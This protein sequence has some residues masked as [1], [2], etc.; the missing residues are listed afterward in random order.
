MAENDNQSQTEKDSKPEGVGKSKAMG[1]S[2]SPITGLRVADPD[3]FR[4][5]AQGVSPLLQS[6]DFEAARLTLQRANENILAMGR[7]LGLLD[8]GLRVD[9]YPTTLSLAPPAEMTQLS[10]R[11]AKIE[12]GLN[13][14]KAGQAKNEKVDEPLL[15]DLIETTA[16]AKGQTDSMLMARLH[17]PPQ[18]LT[19]Q[20][21]VPVTLLERLEEYRSDENLLLLFAGTF[22]GAILGVLGS[23]FV[24]EDQPFSKSSI[25]FLIL[26]VSVTVLLGYGAYALRRR[27]AALKQKMFAKSSGSDQTIPDGDEEASR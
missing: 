10:S 5:T 16:S 2:V 1:T 15:D 20:Q 26:L 12:Q 21:L 27:S 7:N 3:V 23:W 25:L 13:E 8:G 18:W 22:G 24:A 6:P 19:D 9:S 11:L 17:L 14:L 4:Q